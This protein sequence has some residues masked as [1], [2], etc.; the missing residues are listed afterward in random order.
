MRHFIFH[1][2]NQ[3]LKSLKMVLFQYYIT[4]WG[5]GS[6]EGQT[7]VTYFLNSLKV[8]FIMVRKTKSISM[9]ILTGYAAI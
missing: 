1:D 8:N 7:H 3:S 4:Q 2:T 5:E 9:T 6:E